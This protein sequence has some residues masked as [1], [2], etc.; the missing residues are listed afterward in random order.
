MIKQVVTF[1]GLVFFSILV[2]GSSGEGVPVSS[3]LAQI[4]N[5]TVLL[6]VIY[7]TQRKTIVKAF[8]EKKENFMKSVEESLASKKLA[9][10]KYDEVSKRLDEMKSS[11]ARQIEEAK[12]NSEELYLSQVEEAKKEAVRLKSMTRANLEFEIQR[13][14]ESIRIETFQKSADLAEKKLESSLT[15]EQIKAWN[16]H[17]VAS[18]QGAH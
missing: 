13:Q 14:V 5:L 17:F 1:I 9:Q 15:P 12:I 10:E 6:L 8:A 16:T 11:F 7:F 2:Q 3:L 18:S 4:G